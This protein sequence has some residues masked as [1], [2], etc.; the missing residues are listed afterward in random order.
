MTGRDLTMF[1]RHELAAIVSRETEHA[2]LLKEH[3]QK[4]TVRQA[5]DNLF[6]RAVHDMAREADNCLEQALLA[7]HCNNLKLKSLQRQIQRVAK[8]SDGSSASESSDSSDPSNALA[9]SSSDESL[10]SSRKEHLYRKLSMDEL[11]STMRMLVLAISPD[12]A[13]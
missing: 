10:Q 1:K 9:H 13:I 5:E 3:L 11:L 6:F 12:F 8:G 4:I 7:P 2:E